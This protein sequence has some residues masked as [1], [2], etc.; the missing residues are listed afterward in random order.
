[1]QAGGDAP[2]EGARALMDAGV[3]PICSRVKHVFAAV[4]CVAHAF[5]RQVWSIPQPAPPSGPIVCAFITHMPSAVNSV[6]QHAFSAVPLT[7]C[8]H[9]MLI[10]VHWAGHIM[11]P[12]AHA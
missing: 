4:T 7:H 1:M 10:A 2:R 6:G 9:D 11:S 8:T 12:G 3:P 5:I